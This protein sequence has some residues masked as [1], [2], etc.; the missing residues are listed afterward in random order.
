VLKNR[1]V[2]DARR[3]SHQFIGLP[4]VT[5]AVTCQAAVTNMHLLRSWHQQTGHGDPDH[6]L[7]RNDHNSD[8]P[9]AA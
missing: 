1:A 7:L 3:G 5:I 2:A 4:M 8:E 9:F 6:P